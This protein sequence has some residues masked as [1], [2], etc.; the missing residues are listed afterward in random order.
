M[1]KVL[2]G[3]SLECAG[4]RKLEIKIKVKTKIIFFLI[5]NNSIKT[6]YKII[7][8]GTK[9]ANQTLLHFQKHGQDF[10]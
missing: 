8:N 2:V 6:S 7:K 9:G 5:G 4:A 1:F 3:N 10:F